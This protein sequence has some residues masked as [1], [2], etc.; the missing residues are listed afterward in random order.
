MVSTSGATDVAGL[1]ADQ[2]VSVPQ[3]SSGVGLRA[4]VPSNSALPGEL[5]ETMSGRVYG[6]AM[7]TSG[8]TTRAKLPPLL[9]GVVAAPYVDT[10]PG[11]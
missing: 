5:S 2:L 4:T 8:A 9:V 10:L 6:R 3:T 11:F 7:A 1:A